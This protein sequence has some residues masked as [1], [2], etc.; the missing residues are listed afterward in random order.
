MAETHTVTFPARYLGRHA[1]SWNGF[2]NAQGEDVP[3][4]S[5]TVHRLQLDD[6]GQIVEA[7]ERRDQPMTATVPWGAEVDATVVLRPAGNKFRYTLEA[8]APAAAAA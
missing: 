8:L 1:K 3:A 2:R 5:S 6:S 4:G 7:T